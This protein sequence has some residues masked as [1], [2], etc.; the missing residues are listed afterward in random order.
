LLAIVTPSEDVALS[1]DKCQGPNTVRSCSATQL[2]SYGPHTPI[3]FPTNFYHRPDTLDITVVKTSAVTFIQWVRRSIKFRSQPSYTSHGPGTTWNY[4]I[5]D[6]PVYSQMGLLQKIAE[7]SDTR[8]RERHVCRRHR[9]CNYHN[10][11]S[12]KVSKNASKPYHT[13][14]PRDPAIA[15]L[16]ELLR[17]KRETRKTCTILTEQQIAENT[18]S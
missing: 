14:L 12:D 5:K 3:Y 2:R 7:T 1:S 10:Y 9:R 15:D 17:I 16:E 8:K 4:T 11:F 13:Y 6:G 18:A